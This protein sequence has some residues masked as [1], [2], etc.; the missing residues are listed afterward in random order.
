MLHLTTEPLWAESKKN[1]HAI[2]S[3]YKKSILMVAGEHTFEE[4]E[5][6]RKE[7]LL[8]KLKPLTLSVLQVDTNGFFL[9]T[10]EF[11]I[12]TSLSFIFEVR[13]GT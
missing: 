7:S 8:P 3:K 11:T 1:L 9:S 12:Q 13:E 10:L 2:G 4:T 5:I 6:G